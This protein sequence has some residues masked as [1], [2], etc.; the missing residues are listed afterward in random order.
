MFLKTAGR[1][2]RN[3][4]K[5]PPL[6]KSA[7][8]EIAIV[9]GGPIGLRVAERTASAGYETTVLENKSVIGKPVQCAGLVS[10]RV[11]SLTK[12]DH[13][14]HRPEEAVI[15][16]PSGKKL[17]LKNEPEKAVVIDRANFDRELAEKAI[18]AGATI[19]LRKPVKKIEY[20]KDRKLYIGDRGKKRTLEPQ[21]IVGADGP[22]SIVRESGDFPSPEKL[23]PAIQVVVA[24]KD[25]SV[26]IHLGDELATDFFL[27]E[28]PYR[29]GKLIG[30][31]GE[32]KNIYRSLKKFLRHKGI[33]DKVISF[34]SGTIPLGN[35]T[36]SVDDG[37]LLV[38]D[39]ASQVK[40]M[41]GGGLYYGLKAADICSDVIIDALDEDDNSRERLSEY[42][43]R[44]Q[45]EVGEYISKGMKARKIFNFLSDKDLDKLI[46]T[47]SKKEARRVIEEKGDID[48]PS[49][50]V[51]PLLKAS[52]ELSKFIGPVIKSLF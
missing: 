23:L 26:Q 49:N 19:K 6:S 28:V 13:V 45:K 21:I 31:A 10:P 41:S 5:R 34:L 37:V 50:L 36:K 35:M 32:D 51:K 38:G 47:L 48:H 22:S 33:E 43:E 29:S 40:P 30:L 52:P 39:A 12:T 42:H 24:S 9:G 46:E 3:V 8:T 14:I 27:W 18:K 44:W 16:S 11:I 17:I 20:K 7:L 25:R 1:G 4:K 2:K 15:N